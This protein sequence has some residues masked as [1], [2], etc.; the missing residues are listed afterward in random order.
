MSYNP[1]GTILFSLTLPLIQRVKLCCNR[2]VLHNLLLASQLYTV[3][4][5]QVTIPSAMATP[6]SGEKNELGG[7]IISLKIPSH[8]KRNGLGG[9]KQVINDIAH[10]LRCSKII[11]EHKYEYRL[12][13]KKLFDYSNMVVF[14]KL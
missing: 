10:T 1:H 13:H 6:S 11:L 14:Y 2:S 8:P 9:E 7:W 5:I 12:K 4:Q 3:A